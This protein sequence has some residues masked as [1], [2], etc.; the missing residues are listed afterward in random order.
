MTELELARAIGQYAR[1]TTRDLWHD[2]EKH[3]DQKALE[4]WFWR[5]EHRVKW[6]TRHLD[7]A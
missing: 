5:N 2:W 4:V 1:F 7:A 3:H 6:E